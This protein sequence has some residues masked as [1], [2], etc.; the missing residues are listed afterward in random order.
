MNRVPKV[1]GAAMLAAIVAMIVSNAIRQPTRP[2]LAGDRHVDFGIVKVRGKG[3]TL[4]HT[5]P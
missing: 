4:R 1:I 5:S 3:E 2:V